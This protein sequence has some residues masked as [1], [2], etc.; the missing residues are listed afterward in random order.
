VNLAIRAETG[1]DLAFL[2]WI[3]GLPGPAHLV[4]RNAAAAGGFLFPVYMS[5]R[6]LCARRGRHAQNV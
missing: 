3:N 5:F 2:D 6:C 4:A 1:L